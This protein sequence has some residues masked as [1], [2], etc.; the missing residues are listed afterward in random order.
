[1]LAEAKRLRKN[2]LSLRRMKS[3]G[4]EY[5]A[6][7]EMLEGSTDRKRMRDDLYRDIRSYA[8][9][10]RTYWKRNKDIRWFTPK[11]A[12]AVERTVATWLSR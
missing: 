12:A 2:G 7:A 6:L 8:K 10:Q 4:L 1:M 11:D 5:R 9:R 3:L